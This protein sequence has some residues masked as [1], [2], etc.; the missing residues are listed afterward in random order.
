M[1]SD[2]IHKGV[3]R[4]VRPFSYTFFPLSL[5][6]IEEVLTPSQSFYE[7]LYLTHLFMSLIRIVGDFGVN[8][9]STTDLRF[10]R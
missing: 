9:V 8:S 2:L 10:Q 1:T 4:V 3:T 5:G 7:F 6:Y